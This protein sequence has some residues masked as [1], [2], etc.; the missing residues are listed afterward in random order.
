MSN[1]LVVAARIIA[2]EIGKAVLVQEAASLAPD[3]ELVFGIA[4]IRIVAE[5][6]VQAIAFG[7]I[8]GQPKV[9]TRWNPLSRE[10]SDLEPFAFALENYLQRTSGR[11][12]LPRIWLPHRAALEVV[13]ILGYRYRTNRMASATLQRMGARCMA[14]IEEERFQGQQVVAVAGNLLAAHVAT[15]QSPKEDQHL[16]SLLAWI[17]PPPG[18]DVAEEAARRA[19]V[20]AA[21][22]LERSIDD[23][24][25]FL[26]RQG[27]KRGPAGEA[28]RQEIHERLREG[29]VREWNLLV[30][31]RN[32]FWNLGLHR[33]P[34][35]G[36]VLAASANRA[37]YSMGQVHSPRSRPASLARLL[38]DLEQ[39]AELAEDAQIRGD[40][41]NQAKARRR[42][43]VFSARVLKK[44]QPRTSCHP[45]HLQMVTQQEVLRVRRETKLGTLDG[46]LVG[47]VTRVEDHPNGGT[48]IELKLSKGVKG[49]ANRD[50]M[51]PGRVEDWSDSVVED[52]SFRTGQMHQKVKEAASPLVYGDSLP[53]A[54]PRIIFEGDLVALG[55]RLRRS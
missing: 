37:A 21:A 22:M 30:E 14:L 18:V 54:T 19:L 20:P 38:S 13:E 53:P 17:A 10:S 32:A 55:Q 45:C 11:G 27:K 1:D 40:T 46:Q 48:M 16:G 15:G 36:P 4:P 6:Q 7:S 41:I 47:V 29:A 42:G 34:M 43:R 51:T 39:A 5:Q 49:Q 25:E 44:D 8:F 50:R 33:N 2:R 28:A 12:Q 31:A 9:V 3:P 26:R 52:R 24:V 35:L 23:R